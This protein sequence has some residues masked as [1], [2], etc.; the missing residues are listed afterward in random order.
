MLR[1][2]RGRALALAAL[3]LW[4]PS[5]WAAEEPTPLTFS[6]ALDLAKTQ[7]PEILEAQ[8][9][10][11]QARGEVTG[12]S[13][14]LHEN[15]S[16][17][18]GAGPRRTPAGRDGWNV[19]LGLSQTVEL[20]GKRG[21][22]RELAKSSLALEETELQL[23][24]RRAV[25]EAAIAYMKGLHAEGRVALARQSVATAQE[26]SRSAQRRFE[27]GEAPGVDVNL[28]KISL[29]RAQ[30]EVSASEA[31]VVR[32]IS[33]LKK[34]LG[35]PAGTALQLED[36]FS[37]LALA[38]VTASQAPSPPD[39]ASRELELQKARGALSVAQAK[40]WPDVTLGVGYE[41]EGE[42]EAVVG[43]LSVP[44]P[45][46][47]RAQGEREAHAAQVQGASRALENARV[48]REVA[49]EAA[50]A[51]HRKCVEAAQTLKTQ[52]LPW[53]EENLSLSQRSYRA[54]EMGL[55]ELLVVR[56][57]AQEAQA[58]YLDRLLAAG[59]SRIDALKALGGLP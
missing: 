47:A 41:R 19:E 45:L 56:R 15:P 7:S 52:A 35:L 8:S 2:S 49:L 31:E 48:A 24:L 59:V 38:P 12:A 55:A 32:A 43:T 4:P 29:A 28:G 36:E 25:G 5:V 51:V 14:W 26:L 50:I 18:A 27:L 23:A 17:S 44:L 57:E 46:F 9:R 16:L 39:I 37:A 54:G 21:A 34:L 53:V 22:R 6:Q 30:A 33:E 13:A 20:G 3:S 10:V 1:V 58:E 11:A 42:E 40:A